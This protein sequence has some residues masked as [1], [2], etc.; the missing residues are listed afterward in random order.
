MCFAQ[1]ISLLLFSKVPLSSETID[2]I[3]GFPPE[4]PS[5]LIISRLRCLLSYI[6]GQPVILFYTSFSD[7][8]L[9]PERMEDPWYID[10]L[11]QKHF[12]DSRR[13]AIMES[14]LHFN[15]NMCDLGTSFVHNDD[16]LGLDACIYVYILPLMKGESIV[17]THYSK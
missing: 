8:L 10:I 16:I 2:S 12:I 9:S 3:L 4:K 11:S 15:L 17:A 6:P 13:F 5:H 14:M 1:V 7:Y